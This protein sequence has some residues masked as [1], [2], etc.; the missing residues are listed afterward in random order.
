MKI[1]LARLQSFAE[2]VLTAA[3]ATA[4]EAAR[5]AKI[6]LWADRVGRT[7]QGVERLPILCERLERNMMRSPLEPTWRS[8]GKA[9]CHL[10]ANNGIGHLAAELATEKAIE[11]GREGGIGAVAVANSNY[12]GA[13]GYFAWLVAEA[14]MV[15]LVFS[16]SFPKVA[17]HG[18]RRAVL[19]TNP[20]AFAAPIAAEHPL[21]LDL[22]TAAVA[23]SEIRRRAAAG[24]ELDPTMA[25]D[26]AGAPLL[27]PQRFEE[28]V[29]L[30]FGGAKGFGF[31]LLVETLAGAL[32]GGAMGE[33]VKSVYSN[34]TE[35]NRSG[36]FIVAIA[37][38]RFLPGGD[39]ANR[40]AV[41]KRMVAA[42]GDE[43]RLPGDGR[44]RCYDR[45]AAEGIDAADIPVDRLIELGNTHGADV[46]F[47]RV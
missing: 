27:D 25:V 7:E 33:E 32:T 17:A 20:M 22:A 41:M 12:F 44:W 2:T 39:F 47:L 21:L 13:A 29:A 4:D 35:P 24:I 3:G 40:M 16:N 42:S 46:E 31:M 11:L 45:T 6:L 14:G 30:P 15:G 9:A 19:G 43:V 28:G 23:G 34:W 26:A 10:D 1:E 36:H 5:L 37:P 18:G 38:D 8:A